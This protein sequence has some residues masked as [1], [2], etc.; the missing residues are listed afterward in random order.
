MSD[1]NPPIREIAG[2]IINA[3]KKSVKITQLK[4]GKF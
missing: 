1:Q 4:E 3:A 2:K